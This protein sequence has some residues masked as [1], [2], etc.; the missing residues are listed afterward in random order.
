MGELCGAHE[1]GGE[2]LLKAS[3]S[4]NI[5]NSCFKS[6][7]TE[8]SMQA[9]TQRPHSPIRNSLVG[10]LVS[11]AAA[12]TI[13]FSAPLWAQNE[14]ASPTAAVASVPGLIRYSGRLVDG[15]GWPITTSV[16]VTFAIYSQPSGDGLP[17]LWQEIQQIA[18]NSKGGYTALL[19]S[20]S[21]GG[22]PVEI[23]RS[24]ESRYLGVT[25]EGEPEEPRVLIV[26]VPYALRAADATTLGGLPASALSLLDSVLR[27]R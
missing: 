11:T 7:T 3:A 8:M 6:A 19:G 1:F 17:A 5:N 20:V 13:I 16:S 9:R 25:V 26:S 4:L 22:I 10:L 24:G 18:P 12:S 27:Q 23:F 15:R 14:A 21:P 2:A